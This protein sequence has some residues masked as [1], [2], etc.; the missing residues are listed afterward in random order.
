MNCWVGE[1]EER[2]GMKEEVVPG[3]AMLIARS[4]G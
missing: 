2:E 1:E 4:K 3:G